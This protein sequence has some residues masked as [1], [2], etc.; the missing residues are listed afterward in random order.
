[1]SA[2]Q[3]MMQETSQRSRESSKHDQFSK[4]NAMTSGPA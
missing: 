2:K 3:A 1:M 4:G